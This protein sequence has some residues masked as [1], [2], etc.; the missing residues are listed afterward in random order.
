MFSEQIQGNNRKD[1]RDTKKLRDVPP[2][3]HT[4]LRQRGTWQ[5]RWRQADTNAHILIRFR[6]GM[7]RISRSSTKRESDFVFPRALNIPKA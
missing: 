7:R 6:R 5:P 3:G 2:V 4:G 1:A